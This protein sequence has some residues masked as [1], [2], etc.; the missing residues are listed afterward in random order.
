MTIASGVLFGLAM[1]WALFLLFFRLLAKSD[2]DF[3]LATNIW[4][5]SPEK[6]REAA[7]HGKNRQRR[8]ADVVWHLWPLAAA[9]LVAA[10]VLLLL[11]N[12]A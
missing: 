3:G 6:Q 2:L 9:A 5:H 7:E 1:I 11:V 8:S 4:E 10:V 12:A